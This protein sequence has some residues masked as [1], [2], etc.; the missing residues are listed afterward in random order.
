[1]LGLKELLILVVVIA[2]CSGSSVGHNSNSQEGHFLGIFYSLL[3]LFF[4]KN[5]NTISPLGNGLGQLG[6][7]F[8]EDV[9]KECGFTAKC[10]EGWTKRYK[11]APEEHMRCWCYREFTQQEYWENRKQL[12]ESYRGTCTD[13]TEKGNGKTF[14]FTCLLAA[15]YCEAIDQEEKRKEK[16]QKRL[17]KCANFKEDGFQEHCDAAKE[18]CRSL[19]DAGEYQQCG[20]YIS[21]CKDGKGYERSCG[22]AF[23]WCE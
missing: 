16:C 18:W 2:V 12:C 3:N 15:R 20:P 21:Q 23:E 6:Q 7:A 9:K 10:D 13:E 1:M 22:L 11:Q 14:E 19:P 17:Q 4:N 8:G 5:S